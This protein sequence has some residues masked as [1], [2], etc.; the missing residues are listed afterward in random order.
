MEPLSYDE[1]IHVVE[2]RR[3]LDDGADG[4][5]YL[6]AYNN[7]PCVGHGHPRVAEAI[8]RQGRRLNT[9][10]RYLHEIGDRARGAPDRDDAAGAG[11]DT[12]MF[13]NSG[14]EANDVAWRLATTFT[15][16]AARCAR[17]SPTTA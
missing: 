1:P 10:M 16:N 13:V 5:R 11:L 8:A 9:N 17:R 12:V 14:S 4:R 3:R 15:G 7:V 2:R 6:D